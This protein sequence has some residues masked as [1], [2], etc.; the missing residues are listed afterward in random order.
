MAIAFTP[1]HTERYPLHTFTKEEFLALFYKT[2]Q[3]LGWRVLYMSHAGMIA[4]TGI[5]AFTRNSEIKITFEENTAVIQSSSTGGEMADW[6]KNEIKVNE[7]LSTLNTTIA[8]SSKEE[9]HATYMLLKEHFVPEKEDILLLPPPTAA[10][11][12]KNFFSIFI[13]NKQQL[14]TPLLLNINIL[15]FILMIINGADILSPTSESLLAWGASFRPATL[16][17]EWWRLITSCFVHI[18]IIHLLMN[19]YAL[20]NIG[21]I[22]EPM[23]GKARFITAYMLAGLTSSITSLWWHD[24]AVSAGASGAIFG[25]YGVFLALLTSNLI[26][27]D[28]RKSLLSSIGVFVIYNLMFGMLGNIDNS[29]HIGGLAGGFL[30]GLTFIPGM[31]HPDKAILKIPVI[32]LS[33]LA[34][35]AASFFV[36]KNIPNDIG[37]YNE[38]M[39]ELSLLESK[40]LE[41]EANLGTMTSKAEILQELTTT[42]IGNWKKCIEIMNTTDAL[43]LPGAYLKRNRLIKEYLELRLEKSQLIYKSVSEN[44]LMYDTEISKYEQKIESKVKE[45]SKN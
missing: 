44:T 27:K 42:D 19:M 40:A 10:E 1:K 20:V 12:T 11:H 5:G 25:M 16:S 23:I 22:L 9:L 28:E 31:L 15:I 26:H 43:N 38:K 24:Y 18:G 37:I 6:G 41:L 17:G 34:I 36:Y 39:K 8:S 29:G 35:L 3:T 4:H 14:F 13:P 32:G 30:I 2:A 45:F 33:I 21:L 7:F